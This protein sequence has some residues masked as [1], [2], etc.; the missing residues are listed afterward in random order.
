MEND[1]QEIKKATTTINVLL[2]PKLQHYL[3][4]SYSIE[5]F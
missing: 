5:T 4:S 3:L 1:K 2:Q